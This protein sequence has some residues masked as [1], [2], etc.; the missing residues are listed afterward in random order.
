MAISTAL[1]HALAALAEQAPLLVAL[2]FDGTLA[3]LEDDPEL[4]RM[5]P[6]ARAAL[7]CLV[8][9]PGVTIAIVTGRAIESI[10][11]VG[12]PDPRWW[13]VGSHGIEVVAPEERA[14]YQTPD[15][16]PADLLEGFASVVAQFPGARLERKPFGLSVHT[17][18]VDPVIA[19]AA[20]A[21]AR[22]FFLNWAGDVLIRPGHGIVEGALRTSTKGDGIEAV[23]LA[24]GASATL[25]A[26][27]DVTDEDGFAVLG[28]RDVAIRVGGGTTIAPYGV[29]DAREMA[30]VLQLLC[31]S[32]TGQ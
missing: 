4:S 2:D 22:D 3:P 5:I 30:T 15:I 25:F 14:D 13:L 17:R 12:D 23:R 28:G 19:A 10:M 31:D 18:G 21:S 24:L 27:D 16:V 26:G 7:D 29:V 32:F 9:V 1:Q 20:E 6:P 8:D 11:R